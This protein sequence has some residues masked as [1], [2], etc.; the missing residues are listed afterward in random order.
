MVG[1]PKHVKIGIRAHSPN[2]WNSYYLACC[3]VI[4]VNMVLNISAYVSAERYAHP[5]KRHGD[6]ACQNRI[7]HGADTALIAN[8]EADKFAHFRFP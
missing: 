1:I 5:S 3:A 7:F 4:A 2:P 8:K 6:D